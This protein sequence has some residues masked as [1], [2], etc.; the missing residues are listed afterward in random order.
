MASDTRGAK[1]RT[2][3]S[4]EQERQ[5]QPHKPISASKCASGCDEENAKSAM[6][7]GGCRMKDGSTKRGSEV[8]IILGSLV[9]NA[10]F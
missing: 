4:R 2:W 3:L 7:S 8:R 5:R 9:R 1:S 10:D 6:G